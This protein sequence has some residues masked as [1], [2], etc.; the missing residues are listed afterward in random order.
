M[1][2]LVVTV[3]AASVLVGACGPA[4][5]TE[6]RT[7]SGG[8]LDCPSDTVEYS[9]FDYGPDA[10][11]SATAIGALRVLTPDL[12]LPLGAPLVETEEDDTTTFVFTDDDGN[13]LGR[14]SAVQMDGGWVVEETERCG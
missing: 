10:Q 5:R 9:H 12:G 4:I 2:R 8:V 7:N 14:A 13:R 1:A 3:V 6:V 11:G